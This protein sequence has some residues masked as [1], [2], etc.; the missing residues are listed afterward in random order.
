MC[1]KL[2]KNTKQAV[3]RVACLLIGT[4]L[5]FSP[6][7]SDSSKRKP[8]N[9]ITCVVIDAGHGG[10]D[11]GCL[12]GHSREKDVTLAIAL[13]LGKFIET[14][15]KDVKVVYTRKMD[16]FIGL[17][18]RAEIA[19]NNKA[20][21]F[22]CI[23]ANS[24][25]KAAYGIETYV[26]GLHKTDENLAV[27]KRENSVVIL[28]KDYKKKYEGFDPDSPEGNIIF[29][30]Y[31]NAF[32]E[33]SL[34]FATLVQK[35][36]TN[37]AGR[38]NRGVKQAGFL[39][40][41]KTSMPSVLIETGFLTNQQ[42]E[43]YL[44]SKEGQDKMAYA[45]FRA[46]SS[47][48]KGTGV[49]IE[50]EP[51]EKPK[52]TVTKKP[53]YIIDTASVSKPIPADK[54]EEIKIEIKPRPKEIPLVK[55]DSVSEIK[56]ET[57]TEAPV[58]EIKT[59]TE[60]KQKSDS[61]AKIKTEAVPAEQTATAAADEIYFTVQIATSGKLLPKSSEV[62]QGEKNILTDKMNGL[63]K[64]MTGKYSTLGEALTKNRELR[65][66]KFKD[67]FVVAYHNGQRITLAEAQA[68]LKKN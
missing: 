30:M 14:N 63:Y 51:E 33:Q 15:F 39:V 48:K 2:F 6:L 59:Y 64:Y 62:F 41:F 66:E 31:Q 58:K 9:K 19:N 26:M 60:W 40:L 45:L 1:P 54:K 55:K 8:A 36:A 3:S 27:A 5:I 16:K 24:G 53:P 49:M 57:K 61:S 12:G 65:A 32:L 13:R 25:A 4:V 11:S 38:H 37:F 47:Y 7:D 10:H 35:E 20:D 46:F 29:S 43:R 68:L 52:D 42:D 21:L 17:D 22:I 28:E 50:K 67:A 18:E 44:I 23:H 56:T 34:Q